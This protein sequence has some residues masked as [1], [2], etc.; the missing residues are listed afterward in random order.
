MNIKIEYEKKV[1]A[2]KVD[3]V[4]MTEFLT[5]IK[6]E[7]CKGS[8]TS[9]ALWLTSD[10]ENHNPSAFKSCVENTIH[11]MDSLLLRV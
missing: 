6:R 7:L 8:E 1:A 9:R 2:L 10:K 3:N 4:N 5:Q 11:T